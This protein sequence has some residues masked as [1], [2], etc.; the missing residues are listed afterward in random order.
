ME[1]RK[2]IHDLIERRLAYP[3]TVNTSVSTVFMD[4]ISIIQPLGTR[5]FYLTIFC[6]NLIYDMY[7]WNWNPAINFIINF[8]YENSL[9]GTLTSLLYN[10]ECTLGNKPLFPDFGLA[11]IYTSGNMLSVPSKGKKNV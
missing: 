7:Y 5:Y 2:N 4:Y 9:I 3:N 1:F 10:E 6:L 8:Q 11:P